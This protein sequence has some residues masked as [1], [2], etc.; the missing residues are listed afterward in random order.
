M[1]CPICYE[2]QNEIIF[3]T[4]PC[5]ENIFHNLCM[6]CF[7]SLQKKECPVCRTSFE[8]QVPKILNNIKSETKSELINLIG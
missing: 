1:D 8:K 4:L 2:K 5:S 3:V 7:L 6:I